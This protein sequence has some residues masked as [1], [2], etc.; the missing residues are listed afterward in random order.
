[1]N[2]KCRQAGWSCRDRKNW[3]TCDNEKRL[4]EIKTE[5]I[6]FCLTLCHCHD[7]ILD[8]IAGKPVGKNCGNC[9]LDKDGDKIGKVPAICT[10]SKS[11]CA[12]QVNYA[13]LKSHPDERI[14]LAS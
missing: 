3:K 7:G 13:S 8:V 1:M 2:Q 9:K 10:E 4:Q 11:Q 14:F 5:L 12:V 6:E